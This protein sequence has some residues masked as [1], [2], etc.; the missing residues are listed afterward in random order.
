MG[1]AFEGEETTI[2]DQYSVDFV[3][4]ENNGA[5]PGA[6]DGWEPP[7]LPIALK[8]EPQNGDPTK[9]RPNNNP[10]NWNAPKGTRET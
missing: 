5:I 2:S 8:H 3:M 10:G 9:N 1:M 4:G 7:G 6:S